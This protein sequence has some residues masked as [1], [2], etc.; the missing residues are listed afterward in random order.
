[1]IFGS[2][3]LSAGSVHLSPLGAPLGRGEPSA[4]TDPTQSKFIA[5]TKRPVFFS[6]SSMVI[7]EPCLLSPRHDR[8]AE[9]R[10]R[11]PEGDDRFAEILSV[12][13]LNTRNVHDAGLEV[14][15]W[16]LD[17][18]QPDKKTATAKTHQ[19]VRPHRGPVANRRFRATAKRPARHGQHARLVL[20]ASSCLGIPASGKP[21]RA[22]VGELLLLFVYVT[23]F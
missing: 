16:Q 8:R 15:R 21:S 14:R 22:E 10:G 11:R 12:L 7:R 4:R 17:E 6:E 2:I 9:D 23:L 1:M 19:V 3:D 5:L 13:L 18:R 20:V